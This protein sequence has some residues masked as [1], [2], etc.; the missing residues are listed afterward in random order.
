MTTIN[1]SL[2]WPTKDSYAVVAYYQ[3]EC[4]RFKEYS[5]PRPQSTNK[6]N[7]RDISSKLIG[8][9]ERYSVSCKGTTISRQKLLDE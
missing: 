1:E 5:K 8:F 3:M 6:V 7:P 4:V 9:L 2:P